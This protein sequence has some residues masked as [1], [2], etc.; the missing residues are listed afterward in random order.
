MRVR[1]LP[2]WPPQW[3]G[4]YTG[5]DKFARG[6]DG[7][8]KNLRWSDQTGLLIFVIEYE[9]REHSGNLKLDK[10][11]AAKVIM[12]LT[13]EIGRPIKEIVNIEIAP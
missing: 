10:A 2:G 12:V 1:D 9:G 3:A 11:L 7:T 6:E 8:L 13:P 4:V 5:T